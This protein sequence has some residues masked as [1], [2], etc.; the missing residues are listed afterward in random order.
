MLTV[1]GLFTGKMNEYPAIINDP[2]QRFGSPMPEKH[3]NGLFKEWNKDLG[4]WTYYDVVKYTNSKG[5]N[6]YYEF[7]CEEC[8]HEFSDGYCSHFDSRTTTWAPIGEL[9]FHP[10]YWYNDRDECITPR[11]YMKRYYEQ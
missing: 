4:M 8:H 10:E 11:D 9:E 5:T 6:F 1:K 2:Y 3:D 7:R